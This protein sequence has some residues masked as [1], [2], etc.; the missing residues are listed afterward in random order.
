MLY[1][2]KTCGQR[3]ELKEKEHVKCIHCGG[4]IFMKLRSKKVLQYIA[5]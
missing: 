5:K 3:N 1:L 4:R 2:C